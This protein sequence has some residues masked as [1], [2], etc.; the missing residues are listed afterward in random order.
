MWYSM[1]HDKN[2]CLQHESSSKKAESH[3]V[4]LSWEHEHRPITFFA[5]P[6]MSTNDHRSTV[7]IDFGVTNT[8]SCVGKFGRMDS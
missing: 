5:V 7:R 8:F 2:D 1:D 6:H 3:L 4:H